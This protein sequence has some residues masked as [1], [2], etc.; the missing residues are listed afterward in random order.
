MPHFATTTV[1]V[2]S[3]LRSM[4][5]DLS[6]AHMLLPLMNKGYFKDPPVQ[7]YSCN[8]CSSTL[9][10]WMRVIR[11]TC[12]KCMNMDLYANCYT[13]WKKS[14]GRIDLCKCHTFHQVQRPCWYT[15]KLG[16]VTEDGKTLYE[17]LVYLV[18]H[19]RGLLKGLEKS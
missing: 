12:M 3:P 15:L 2:F 5:A 6:I 4:S 16:T 10:G 7:G 1:L 18:G 9:Y 14:Y 8:G 19:F 11:F 17:V 13:S